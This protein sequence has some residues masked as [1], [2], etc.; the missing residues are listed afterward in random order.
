MLNAADRM[1]SLGQEQGDSGTP[2]SIFGSA[3]GLAQSIQTDKRFRISVYPFLSGEAPDV[4]M[5]LAACLCY[6]LEQY[7]DTRVYRCFAKIDPADDSAEISVSDYQFTVADWEL[8]GLANNVILD[9]AFGTFGNGF[10]LRL[11][12][13]MSLTASETD[14][15]LLVYKFDSAAAAASALPAVALDV[16][17]QMAGEVGTAAILEYGSFE[18]PAPAIELLLENVFAWNLDVYLYFWDV[19]WAEAEI[20]EQFLEVAEWCKESASEFGYWC[21]GM[22]ARQAMQPGLSEAGDVL[23]PLVGRAFAARESVATGAAAAAL[24]LANLGQAQRAVDF[25]A[26]YLRHE[27]AASVWCAMIEIHMGAGHVAEAIDTCQLAL[28]RGLEDSALYWRYAQLLITADVHDWTVEDVLLIDP[29]EYEEEDQLTA[30]IA[31]S[32]KLYLTIRPDDLAALQLALTYMIDAQ[33]DELWLYFEKLLQIDQDG[34]FAADVVDRLCELDDHER[35][36]EVLERQLDSNAYAYA[37][38]AQL[39]LADADPEYA[40][41]MIDACRQTLA[42]VGDDLELELQRLKLQ[43]SLPAFEET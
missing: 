18:A 29:D 5:G 38:L 39:A 2:T 7:P 24:G 36:Y 12:V 37:Y 11:E 17:G 19:A 34:M 15:E 41:A 20:R 3:A 27:A 21:L 35:A 23:V 8:E 1:K 22:M 14:S 32:F 40:T 33:D 9:G 4:A 28:E 43:V 30:E 10:E 16:Y 6:L 42:E 26:P 13:D 31:N 25:L